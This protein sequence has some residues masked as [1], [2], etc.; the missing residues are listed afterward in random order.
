MHM[1]F[2]LPTY[3]T[4]QWTFGIL[5][6]LLLLCGT[7]SGALSG[8]QRV[9]TINPAI[10]PTIT[11]TSS[12][13]ETITC[14]APAECLF[15]EDASLK[16]GNLALR[17]SLKPCGYAWGDVAISEYKY[18]WEKKP[19]TTVPT[20]TTPATT[21]CRAPYECLPRSQAGTKWPTG[22]TQGSDV[23]CDFAWGDVG[24]YEYDYCFEKSVVTV[25][26]T[27]NLIRTNVNPLLQAQQVCPDGEIWCNGACVDVHG[28]DPNNCGGC[29]ISCLLG[30]YC[31]SD[32]CLKGCPM[33]TVNCQRNSCTNLQT[34]PD[35]CGT[36]GNPCAA[37][38]FCYSG[39]CRTDCGPMLKCD[40]RCVDSQNDVK[41][42][43]GCNKVCTNRQYCDKGKCSDICYL[44]PLPDQ[45]S[46][47]S[48]YGTD[49]MTP[50]KDQG[51]CGSCWAEAPVGATEAVHN[52]E[53]G[54]LANMDLSEQSLVSGCNGDVGSC[55][56]G[57][58]TEALGIMQSDGLVTESTYPYRSASCTY[59]VDPSGN[60]TCN[61]S[62]NQ[63]NPALHCS[64]PGIC[65]NFATVSALTGT[66]KIKSFSSIET[67]YESSEDARQKDAQNTIKQ[68]ILCHGPLAACSGSWWHCIVITGWTKDGWYIKNSWGATWNG[69]GYGII[70]YGHPFSATQDPNDHSDFVRSAFSV[71][72][73]YHNG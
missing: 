49:W 34:D 53:Q 60:K 57:S 13:P 55:T 71:N 2:L 4:R 42:C 62:C 21:P 15:A 61:S 64:V 54:W 33:G 73:V 46:W 52:I 16:W 24:I 1:D 25:T 14:Q 12:G 43:G 29:G 59:D 26:P 19:L 37:G 11:T 7:A 69:N 35:N 3:L 50:V 27:L 48:H 22:F 67:M 68:N 23:P 20:V 41:N 36:C 28:S 66:W 8:I 56:G 45:F 18:C 32:M 70:P 65:N 51:S 5:L 10:M 39:K 63:N 17:T 30:E 58:M 9:A 44:K 38:E 6:S 40:V 72:G 47:T 31:D